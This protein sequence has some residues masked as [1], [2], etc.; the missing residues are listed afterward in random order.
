MGSCHLEASFGVTWSV[1]WRY[2]ECY[3][4]LPGYLGVAW[5][6]LGFYL[7]ELFCVPK[8]PRSSNSNFWENSFWFVQLNTWDRANRATKQARH[9]SRAKFRGQNWP[10]FEPVFEAKTGPLE[11]YSVANQISQELNVKML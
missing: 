9:N 10:V 11:P 4:V 7:G 8:Y 5:R 3:L 1:T 2:L 6:S